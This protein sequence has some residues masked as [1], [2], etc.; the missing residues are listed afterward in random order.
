MWW[1]RGCKF[2]GKQGNWLESFYNNPSES[3]VD[4]NMVGKI[5]DVKNSQIMNTFFFYYEYVLMKDLIEL[6]KTIKLIL[7]CVCPQRDT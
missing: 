3:M 6:A 2:G 1:H 7:R 5:K 4:S